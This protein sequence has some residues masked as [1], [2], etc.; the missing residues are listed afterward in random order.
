MRKAQEVLT[1]EEP[2]KSSQTKSPRSPN[3]RKAQDVLTGEKPQKSSQ[4]KSPWSPYRHKAQQVLADE[5]PKKSWQTKS[6]RSPNRR[7]AQEVLTDEKPEKSKQMS[8]QR[9]YEPTIGVTRWDFFWSW[10]EFWAAFHVRDFFC[11]S[12]CVLR[13]LDMSIGPKNDR[14]CTKIRK[15]GTNF[16]RRYVWATGRKGAPL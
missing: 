1:V 2:K 14:T 9:S 8:I 3:R 7:K 15:L 4:T 5:K 6:P 10:A 13:Q 12:N 16:G 11:M